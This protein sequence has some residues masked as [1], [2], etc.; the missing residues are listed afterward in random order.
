M[1]IGSRTAVA[2]KTTKATTNF[3]E[4]TLVGETGLVSV[5]PSVPRS[6]SVDS[7]AIVARIAISATVWPVQP[8]STFAVGSCDR[9]PADSASWV[10]SAMNGI[11]VMKIAP[12]TE[13]PRMIRALG[14]RTHS[15]NS[16]RMTVPRPRNGPL[17]RGCEGCGD[18]LRGL[19]GH[20]ATSFVGNR[21]VVGRRLVTT[22]WMTSA[23]ATIR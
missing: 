5:Q 16:L 14:P 11:S 15:V 19:G 13:T 3:A 1:S 17:R 23:P 21:A 22:E 8:S 9:R 10:A 4:M 2:T 7:S 12:R 20:A 18:E 6:R